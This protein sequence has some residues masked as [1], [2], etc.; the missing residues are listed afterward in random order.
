MPSNW[1]WR[2]K[3][4]PNNTVKWFSVSESSL[5]YGLYFLRATAA[6]G[7]LTASGNSIIRCDWHADST[8]RLV[9]PDCLTDIPQSGAFRC[10]K[11]RLSLYDTGTTGIGSMTA[12]LNLRS[13]SGLTAAAMLRAQGALLQ[14]RD[15][16]GEPLSIGRKSRIVPT[17]LPF[18]SSD[19]VPGT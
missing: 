10:R 2:R 18:P 3:L 8:R 15:D 4:T 1:G 7:R 12:T 13:Q 17:A 5:E 19:T 11:T 6:S 14:T 9:E 16:K